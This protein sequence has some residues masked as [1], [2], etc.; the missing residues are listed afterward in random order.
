MSSYFE[1]EYMILHEITVQQQQQ[2]LI[3]EADIWIRFIR[4][5]YNDPN[6]MNEKQ[7]AETREKMNEWFTKLSKEMQITDQQKE[8]LL[9]GK[10]NITD[11]Y[12]IDDQKVVNPYIKYLDISDEQKKD[13]LHGSKEFDFESMRNSAIQ[14]YQKDNPQPSWYSNFFDKTIDTIADHKVGIGIAG[15][16]AAGAFGLYWLYKKYQKDKTKTA[17]DEQFAERLNND[18]EL[19]LKVAQQTNGLKRW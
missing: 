11:I 18:K 10:L 3:I 5:L 6:I 15:L 13:F 4:Q 2:N 17:A 12:Q 7:K 8:D 14:Q 19:A 9:T 16:I 1:Q